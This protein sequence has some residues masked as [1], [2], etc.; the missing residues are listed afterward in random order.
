MANGDA[1]PRMTKLNHHEVTIY[2]EAHHEK[3]PQ[4]RRS[5]SIIQGKFTA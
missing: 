3:F 2:L 5:N 1:R 4:K